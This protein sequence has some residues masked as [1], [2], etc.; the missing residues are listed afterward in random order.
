MYTHP[1]VHRLDKRE[2]YKLLEAGA[3]TLEQLK[4]IPST[5][6][7]FYGTDLPKCFLLVD[8]GAGNPY[9]L[10]FYM[11]ARLYF[12]DNQEQSIHYYYR[13]SECYLAEKILDLLPARF[14]RH[15]DKEDRNFEYIE[16]P[17]CYWY[18]DRIDEG[19]IYGYVRDLFK[20]IWSKRQSS[21]KQRIC[22]LRDSSCN[23]YFVQQK[24]LVESLKWREFSFYDLD[25]MTAED[26]MC[27]FTNASIVIGAHG[28]GLS[29]IIFCNKGTKICELSFE[30]RKHYKSMAAQC[31]LDFYSYD[32]CTYGEKEAVH[33]SVPDFLEFVDQHLLE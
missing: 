23:R 17:A 9:H 30:D 29:W 26:Q 27:L 16:L 3:V 28:A 12:V 21:E 32:K 10:F 18:A 2:L 6:I 14:I 24:E 33:L 11:I 13:K 19:W 7:L 8:A 5:H 25:K 31:G 4:K 1:L 22:L 20:P 15:F